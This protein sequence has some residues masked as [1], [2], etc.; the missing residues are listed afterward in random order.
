MLSI[1]EDFVQIDIG[2]KSEGLVATWEFMDEDG[3]VLVA[4]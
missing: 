2:F 3:D 1:D 4:G